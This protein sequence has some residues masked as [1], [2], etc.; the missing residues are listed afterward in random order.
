LLRILL[1]II[2]LGNMKVEVASSAHGRVDLLLGCGAATVFARTVLNIVCK[3]VLPPPSLYY[4]LMLLVG[5]IIFEPG[6]LC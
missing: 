3:I 5:T 1:H 4:A 6:T 2:F